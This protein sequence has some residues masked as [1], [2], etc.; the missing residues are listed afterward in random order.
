MRFV[1]FAILALQIT[2]TYASEG[3]VTCEINKGSSNAASVYIPLGHEN[4]STGHVDVSNARGVLVASPQV[5]LFE[6]G[7]RRLTVVAK[8]GR[9]LHLDLRYSW[10][11]E[12]GKAK[13]WTGRGYVSSTDVKCAKDIGE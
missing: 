9:K 8:V 11:T 10:A 4:R 13:V 5:T 2:A 12:G 7:P 1:I 6:N 3:G